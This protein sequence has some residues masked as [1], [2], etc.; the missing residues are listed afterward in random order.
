MKQSF[1]NSVKLFFGPDSIIKGKI[2]L[3]C[4][5]DMFQQAKKLFLQQVTTS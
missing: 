3:F 2:I 5:A 1:P 4:Q